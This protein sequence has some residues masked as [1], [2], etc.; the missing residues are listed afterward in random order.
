[1]DLKVLGEACR[2]ETAGGQGVLATIIATKGST[3]RKAG[4][5]MLVLPDGQVR[6]TIG[7]G[8]AEAAVRQQALRVLAAGRSATQVVELLDSVAGDEGMACGGT[9]EVFLQLLG[10]EGES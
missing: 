6:G 10:G 8:C 9:L 2:L 7:G 3:P 5:Q 4:S 1:M